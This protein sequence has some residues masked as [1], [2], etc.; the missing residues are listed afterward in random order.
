MLTFLLPDFIFLVLSQMKKI[1]AI[2]MSIFFLLN[3][4]GLSVYA[5]YCGNELQSASVMVAADSCCDDDDSINET[6]S[7][8]CHNKVET[9]KI[10]DDFLS[11]AKIQQAKLF[12]VELF[13]FAYHITFQ[14]K[15]TDLHNPITVNF[16][17]S[18]PRNCP[19]IL[20]T[21]TFLI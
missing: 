9:I 11:I 18:P 5:H 13:L 19:I 16:K 4:V 12:P 8:C 15:L 2:V 3:V 7:D 10:K 14:N 17:G 20:L 1:T 21:Q 6:Q